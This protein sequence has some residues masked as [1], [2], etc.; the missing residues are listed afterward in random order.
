MNSHEIDYKIY[1][2]DLQFVEIEL[3]P[4]ETVIAEAGAMM[5]MEDGVS[6][7]TKMGDGSEP[8]EGIIDKIFSAGKRV[9]SRESI[10][11]THFTSRKQG[12]AHVAFAAP[13]PG[14]IQPIDLSKIGGEFFCQKNSFL[15]AALGTKI[16]IAFAKRFGAGLFGGE[17]FI[18]QHLLGDGKAFLHGSGT[19]IKKELRGEKLLVDTGCLVGF[20]KGI[21]YSIEKAGGLKTMLFGGEGIFLASLS[22]YGTVL[23]QSMPFSRMAEKIAQ[24]T[25]SQGGK[26]VGEGSLLG[27][28]SNMFER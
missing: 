18:L 1:G 13:Y 9:L 20:T 5:Y 15:V 10:F 26:S 12:K 25:V 17:G 8:N 22:G 2:D 27:G 3:D 21:D 4:N 19:I 6:F 23:L 28:I 24:A 14:K 7:E 11:L 16:S